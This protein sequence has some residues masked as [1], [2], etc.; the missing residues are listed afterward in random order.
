MGALR[1]AA[2]SRW[3]RSQKK[4]DWLAEHA[5]YLA[6]NRSRLHYRQ[7]RPVN[8]S[9]PL[10]AAAKEDIYLDCSS[11][12]QW[13]YARGNVTFKKFGGLPDPSNMRHCG[14]GNTYS[15]EAHGTRVSVPRKGDLAFYWGMSR[16]SSGRT[17]RTPGV[18]RC[19][20]RLEVGPLILR[21]NYRS[22]LH[23][24]FRRYF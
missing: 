11:I 7:Y 12:V 13:L 19:L 9:R 18:D 21:A 4:R 1:A 8:V 22:D 24:G 5:L 16:S 15:Q 23:S 6:N 20:A 14:Y 3:L 17:R 10:T 2:P